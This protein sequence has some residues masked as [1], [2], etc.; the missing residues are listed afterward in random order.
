MILSGE[1]E[2]A[3]RSRAMAQTAGLTITIAGELLPLFS[4]LLTRGFVV[5]ARVGCSIEELL[6]GQFGVAKQ[7]LEERVQSLFLDGN[8]MDDVHAPVI[9]DGSV[10]SLSAALPGL[11]GAVLR[12]GGYYAAMRGRIAQAGGAV[13]GDEGGA[14]R[15]EIRLFNFTARELG[16][17]FLKRGILV[18][19]DDLMAVLADAAERLRKV[20]ATAVLDGKPVAVDELLRS[21]L[22]TADIR[23]QVI[24]AQV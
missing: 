17:L 19:T 11:A 18:R 15:V 1:T 10:L 21:P 2:D 16:P 20:G 5:E 9:R 22:G 23:L 6:C 4:G 14:G 7:Y 13:T 12:K 3:R 24:A 8:A